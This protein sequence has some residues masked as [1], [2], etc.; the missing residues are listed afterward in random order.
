MKRLAWCAL[1][2]T[3]FAASAL[4]PTTPAAAPAEPA[5]PAKPLVEVHGDWVT[6]CFP[7]KSDSPCD[8]LFATVRKGTQQRVTEISIAYA[9]V[10]NQYVMQL[11][12]PIG[13]DL[14]QGVVID[15]EGYRSGSL[16]IRRCDRTGCFVEMAVSPQL[17]TGLRNAPNPVGHLNV[18]ADGGRPVTLNVSL[19]GFGDA[20]DAMVNLARQKASGQPLPLRDQ[21]P[22][23]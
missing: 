13:I 20:H 14:T 3:I 12:V 19:N 15:A 11:M 18:V 8:V 7:V 16:F 6:R 22:T 1:A 2:V 5:A 21:A 9:P 10:R 23:P 17:I 4:A